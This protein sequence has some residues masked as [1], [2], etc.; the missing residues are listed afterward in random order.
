[1]KTNQYD[2]KTMG[3]ADLVDIYGATK[4]D[5]ADA[6]KIVKTIKAEL[7]RRKKATA[8]SR[9]CVVIEGILFRVSITYSMSNYLNTD[10]VRELLSARQLIRCIKA[11]P[12]Y[13]V[14]SNARTGDKGK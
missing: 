13:V 14:R 1:M 12:K 4:A 6:A 7:L 5:E 3:I 10:K 2:V 9:G 11:V 8:K